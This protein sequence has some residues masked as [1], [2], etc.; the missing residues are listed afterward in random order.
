MKRLTADPVVKFF[1]SAIGLI[2]IFAFLKELQHIFVPFVIAYFLFFGFEPLNNKL[3]RRKFPRWLVTFSDIIIMLAVLAG[4]SRLII[5][6][7][8]RFAEEFPLYENKLNLL[9]SNAARSMGIADPSFTDFKISE[10][11]VSMDIGGLASGIFD[12]TFSLFTMLIF[13]VFFFIFISSGH[14]KL[15]NAVLKRFVRK[16]V[17]SSIKQLKKEYKKLEKKGENIEDEIEGLKEIKSEREL[18]IE[19]TF[20]DITIQI[21]KYIATKFLISLST[22]IILSFVL[23]LFGIDFYIVWGVMTFFLNFIPNLGS[24]FY[25][26]LPSLMTLLQYESVGYTLVVAIVLIIISNIL[27]NLIEPKI[28]GHRL[29]INPLVILLSLLLWG[30]IWGIPGM[31]LSV[32]L[33]AIVKIMLSNLDTKNTRFLSNLMSN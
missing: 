33:T 26:L 32:P 13:V 17:S 12:S 1:I 20:R 11:A 6:S 24:V 19:K 15:Y 5:G 21:Q 2:L 8:S 30:Y 18:L 28:F 27:G 16:Q 7:F 10:Y 14:K 25:V 9:I 23:C 3:F 29:G 22:G 4:I 31:F